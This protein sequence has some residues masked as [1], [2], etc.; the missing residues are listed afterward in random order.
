MVQNKYF[1][2]ALL[3]LVVIFAGCA[4]QEEVQEDMTTTQ[5]G[6][7]VL[8]NGEVITAEDVQEAQMLLEQ[9][10]QQQVSQQQATDVLIQQVLLDQEAAR[11][12]VKPSLEEAEVLLA[13]QAELSGANLSA[14]QEQLG[15]EYEFFL[16]NYQ[17]QV[18]FEA[19]IDAQNVSVISDSDIQ[20]FY[21][22]NPEQFVVGNETVSFEEAQPQIRA[23]LEQQRDSQAIQQLTQRLFEEAEI[24]DY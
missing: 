10:A 20:A 11:L 23:F 9:Q 16:Y 12:G 6:P 22:E 5:T 21:D 19:L 3:A 1:V 18:M 7:V 14:F 24:V 2:Y 4:A 13:E 8:V 17:Q 15:E